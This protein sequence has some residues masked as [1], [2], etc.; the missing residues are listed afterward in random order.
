M[1]IKIKK[2]EERPRIKSWSYPCLRKVKSKLY[3]PTAYAKKKSAK[4]A[5]VDVLSP[6][7]SQSF[8][9]ART[10]FI[11]WWLGYTIWRA[12]HPEEIHRFLYSVKEKLGF[13]FFEKS[14]IYPLHKQ[15]K[16][17]AKLATVNAL[18]LILCQSFNTKWTFFIF[19]FSSQ[20]KWRTEKN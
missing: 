9:R 16:E 5:T 6:F 8:N 7:F 15:G 20:Y 17:S 11:F 19:C 10:L 13:L 4:V 3:L 18:S 12:C 1:K 2:S 14:C